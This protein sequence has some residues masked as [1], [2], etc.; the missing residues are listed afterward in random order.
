MKL[1]IDAA[2]SNAT[3]R[4]QK[5]KTQPYYTSMRGAIKSSRVIFKKKQERDGMVQKY[6][7]S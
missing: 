1:N 7:A 6:I 3:T 4:R 2:L 5:K